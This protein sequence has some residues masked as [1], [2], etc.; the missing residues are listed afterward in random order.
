[1]AIGTGVSLGFFIFCIYAAYAYAFFIG[2]LWVD[3]ER[4]NHTF[5]RTYTAG[6]T[7]SVFFGVLF[8][9]FALAGASPQFAAVIEGKSAAKLAFDV[10]NRKPAIN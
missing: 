10:I 1:M 7:L 2:A 8:G 6:D 3:R 4:K 5:D 9:L